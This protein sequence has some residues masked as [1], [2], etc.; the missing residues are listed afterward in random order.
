M[1]LAEI[2]LNKAVQLFFASDSKRTEILRKDAYRSA[3]SRPKANGGNFHTA[4]WS[5]A[6]D[7][8]AGLLDLR[9]ATSERISKNPKCKRLYELLRDGFLQLWNEKRR[10]LNEP[11]KIVAKNIHGQFECH[12]CAVSMR[13]ALHVRAG[14]FYSRIVYPY[15]SEEPEL[16]E[17]G[18][19]LIL[20]AMIEAL[21]A[22]DPEEMRIIDV[23]RAKSYSIANCPLRGDEFE[24]F[25]EKISLIADE[26][27]RL[28]RSYD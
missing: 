5:D 9:E 12:P 23:I 1:P 3:R 7:H 13:G 11:V 27:E 26:W 6:K 25:E 18:A 24:L 4:F 19:R 20:W 2:P 16:G 8:V 15:F 10:W 22:H 28:R 17:D 14:D 21:P